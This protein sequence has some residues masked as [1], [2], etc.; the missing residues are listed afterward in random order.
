MNAIQSTGKGMGTT[1][2]ASAMPTVEYQIKRTS[3][4]TLSG[5]NYEVDW[6]ERKLGI[7]FRRPPTIIK[8]VTES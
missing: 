7:S 5:Y 8:L 4:I 1:G 6:Q 2:H 3:F